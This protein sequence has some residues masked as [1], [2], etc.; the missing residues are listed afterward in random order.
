MTNDSK[1][2]T[3]CMK[4]VSVLLAL[5]LV[6]Q[7]LMQ[8]ETAYADSR[9]VFAVSEDGTKTYYRLGDAWTAAN[10][11]TKII[12]QTDWVC[13]TPLDIA[14]NKNVSMNLN[15]HSIS[16]SNKNDVRNG[17]VFSMQSGAKLNLSGGDAS[18]TFSYSP[19]SAMGSS[20]K[21]QVTSGGLITNGWNDIGGGGIDIKG[22][23]CELTL[24]NVA[25]A[26]NRSEFW[27]AANGQGGGIRI[28]ESNCKIYMR[29]QAKICDN[30]AEDDGGGI[31][32]TGTGNRIYLYNG[33][34]I[35][36][37][38]GENGGG[39]Y[40]FKT[41]FQIVS[42]DGTGSLKNNRARVKD[43][44]GGGIYVCKHGLTLSNSGLISNLTFE[45]NSADLMG[46]AI[47]IGQECV[48]V[49]S[50]VITQCA[51]KYGGGIFI[52]NQKNTI[53]NCVINDNKASSEG[54]GVYVQNDCSA[55]LAGECYIKDNKRGNGSNDDV[56]LRGA[57]SAANKNG[58][59]AG[60]PTSKSDIGI[61]VENTSR[62]ELGT[63]E[64]FF[65]E[66]AFFSNNEGYY[67]CVDTENSAK[68]LLKKGEK[69]KN[70]KI[71]VSPEPQ[72][73]SQKYNEQDVIKG[74][75]SYSSVADVNSD[76]D[77]QFFFSDGYFLNGADSQ[78]G[79]PKNYNEHLA[80]MSYA[81]AMS[82]FYS[83]IGNDGAKYENDCAYTYKS[84]NIK[85][86]MSDIGVDA[87]KIYISDTNSVKPT[88]GSIG[89]AIG[90]KVINKKDASE[91]ID[92]DN[93]Y[94][95]IPISVRGAG[96]EAEWTSNVTVGNSGEHSGFADAADQVTKLVCAYIK[97]YGLEEAANNGRIKFWIS[98]YS[99][100]GATSNLT[101][102]RLTEKYCSCV[103]TDGRDAKANSNQVYAYCL[104][105]PQGGV[106]SAM[107]LSEDHY[108]SIHNLINKVD[109]VPL[110]APEEMGF[111]RYGVDHYIPGDPNSSKISSKSNVWSYVNNQ[112]WAKTYKNWYDNSAYTVGTSSYNNQKKKMLE[113]LKSV[114]SEGIQF[115]DKFYPATAT[116]VDS[117][118]TG[119]MLEKLSTTSG[120]LT[121]ESYL[122]IFWRSFQA[123]GLY[124]S[125][126]G[127]FKNSYVN[128]V[129]SS[130]ASGGSKVAF[131]SGIS[132]F[133]RVLMSKNSA[134]FNGMIGGI[135]AGYPALM[136]NEGA[137][138]MW[139]EIFG[140][141]ATMSTSDRNKWT[142]TFW[143]YLMTTKSLNGK[144]FVDYLTTSEV[145]E[146]RAAWDTVFDVLMRFVDVDYNSNIVTWN[147]SKA[148]NSGKT[149]P[150]TE[151]I[152][153]EN[154]KYYGD[155]QVVLAT[156]MY[157]F[158]SIA[159]GH[160]PEINY[161]WVRSYD[162]F[163]DNSKEYDIKT[164][165]VP[166]IVD[167][168]DKNSDYCLEL[169][170][171]TKGASIFYRIKDD[172]TGQFKAWKPYN[173]P[174]SL[175]TDTS[176]SK[177]KTVQMT[178]VY[179][180]NTSQVV[181]KTYEIKNRY[182]V[183]INGEKVGQFKEG[184]EVTIDGNSQDDGKVFRAWTDTD[185]ITLDD[186]S[187]AIAKFKM[188]SRNINL[189]AD[190]INAIKQAKLIVE[191]PK[192]G[193]DL[194]S[195]GQLVCVDSAGKES[196]I[197]VSPMWAE[198]DGQ[199]ASGKA[200]FNT[201]YHFVA[202]VFKDVSSGV[203]FWK[204]IS[205][206]DIE[207]EYIG[208]GTQK[209]AS[210]TVDAASNLIIFAPDIKTEKAKI[211]SAKKIK[212][213]VMR[214]S[215]ESA[216]V[217][218]LPSNATVEAQDGEIYVV[219]VDK[220]NIDFKDVLVSGIVTNDGIVEI[221]LNISQ[222]SSILNT[223]NVKLCVEVEQKD[224]PQASKVDVVTQP[225]T[226]NDTSLEVFLSCETEGAEIS[227]SLDG[228]M[229]DTYHDKIT[230]SGNDGERTTHTIVA[231]AEGG[232]YAASSEVV[233]TYVL[234]NPFSIK[235]SGKDTGLKK[236]GLWDEPKEFKYYKG[237]DVLIGAPLEDGEV[238]QKWESV[239]DGA[240][241]NEETHILS[242]ADLKKSYELTA[243]YNPVVQ[244][245][246]LQFEAPTIGKMLPTKVES[247]KATV[248]NE[249]DITNLFGDISWTPNTES[250]SL[251]TPYTAKII[252]NDEYV[253]DMVYVIS[254]NIKI[255]VNG[256]ETKSW[257]NIYKE[258]GKYVV[259][260][261][262]PNVYSA[263]LLYFEKPQDSGVTRQEASDGE[264]GLP[265][266]TTIV[267][268]DGNSEPAT[269]EWETLP[270]FDS[271]DLYS[272]ELTATGK[273][274]L[275]DYV[276]ANDVDLSVSVKISVPSAPTVSAPQSD[277][278][279]GAYTGGFNINLTCETEGA[280]IYYTVDGSDPTVN[281]RKYDGS[282]VSIE[283]E[284]AK[285]TLKAIAVADGMIESGIS[286]YEYDIEVPEAVKTPVADHESGTYNS[287]IMVDFSCE[288]DDASIYYTLDGT[289]PTR[290]S[291]PYE[292]EPIEISDTSKPT[293]LKLFAV[294]EG[295]SDSE[296]ATYV[297]EIVEEDQTVKTPVADHESGTYS[298]SISVVLTC[299]TEGASIYYTLDGSDPTVSSKSYEDRAI[300][301]NNTEEPT[302]LKAIAAKSVAETSSLGDVSELVSDEDEVS[303]QGGS[304]VQTSE[305]A[306]YTYVISENKSSDGGGA[307]ASDSD[308]NN[309]SQGDSSDSETAAQRHSSANA[310]TGDR[311]FFAFAFPVLAV[312]ALALFCSYVAR[313]KKK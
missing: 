144:S 249:Y 111:I 201:S 137:Y 26:G 182:D 251:N 243:I 59:V 95:L 291:L 83:N 127:N 32:S 4:I 143:N 226:Y 200:K 198:G 224:K 44:S 246:D 290:E 237:S 187:S 132:S 25:V 305:I 152:T 91:K 57:Y 180:G 53:S 49:E 160:Y 289:D 3:V 141:W 52:E 166:V 276:K 110:V 71:E 258:D 195:S 51:A 138:T 13:T 301:I 75:F 197:N 252:V 193:E 303:A 74:Y 147:S 268:S 298:S 31:Y 43:H 120:N 88:T 55:T 244:K 170:T 222:D 98:G 304:D 131:Q 54:G 72:S 151:G 225:G 154:T 293:T 214:Y 134:D 302:V 125:A 259:Y 204:N 37:N 109:L 227:Y 194:P 274:I 117:M 229:P 159:Q 60:S 85:K 312:S 19:G 232:D 231:W 313:K 100:A 265:S 189:K 112:S 94:V 81:L 104:E 106:N 255:V 210:V 288:T 174:I 9:V 262:F 69:P 181:E 310:E 41:D 233:A 230:L 203:A 168:Y 217:E 77:G 273:V 299:E 29:N 5:I 18:R 164:D 295:F 101:A 235:I 218:A 68:L 221:P 207:V 56:Y 253:G 161:A 178:A 211:T 169:S 22:D 219:D 162:S 192:A 242:F 179:C 126:E 236:D 171:E 184:D 267:L 228:E 311:A 190:Y 80:S 38:S 93:D 185:G 34:E 66:D 158:T 173:G 206:K 223:D 30:Y 115:Y 149:T 283:K 275:P 202:F 163:Y 156:L 186:N 212:T 269:I 208:E 90:S 146:L 241:E 70:E 148:L 284:N 256:G 8:C 250:P 7:P 183:T 27:L 130:S 239:P 307:S 114:D 306:T 260:V 58:T 116:Y 191:A 272:Q 209:S 199:S 61:R 42:P 278:C 216:L 300:E 157:N 142:N 118:W 11:G 133:I 48:S 196:T 35:S 123:W 270:S 220:A 87:N 139:K 113:Q 62:T 23:N 46:G 175:N 21:S 177:T 28:R 79:D 136:T 240:V 297:Y 67:V 271:S 135:K 45:N 213:T 50:C 264:W 292:A 309:S 279:S 294:A 277:Y 145:G 24:D 285:T 6:S 124:D 76:T 129:P 282:P 108:Y 121:Q 155:N 150:I 78:A 2:I 10:N 102:K 281:S 89:V 122:K 266:I 105:A 63:S 14:S 16:R 234:D 97:N 205:D 176:V 308:S 140:K 257:A 167:E 73:D 40:L 84:Q 17:H 47:Y 103:A 238:F 36:N 261:T 96:Y 287:K 33:S 286:T 64:T 15:G 188:P 153:N 39:V 172:T 263:D 107:Q 245:L 99:R 92:L 280:T 12:L 165:T 248:T 86:L 82:G 254:D 128:K 247:A 215:L 1:I 65:F 20:T 296:I 119:N